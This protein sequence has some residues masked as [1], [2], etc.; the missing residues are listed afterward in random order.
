MLERA[1]VAAWPVGRPCL[2]TWSRVSIL[3]P[4]LRNAGGKAS[5]ASSRTLQC[6]RRWKAASRGGARFPSA[7]RSAPVQVVTDATRSATRVPV[8]GEILQNDRRISGG[9]LGEQIGQL[10]LNSPRRSRCDAP[11]RASPPGD[12]LAGP[13]D[14]LGPQASGW[15]AFLPAPAPWRE[16][17]DRTDTRPAR[18]T[19]RSSSTLGGRAA[20]SALKR[21]AAAGWRSLQAP[22]VRC[23][24]PLGGGRHAG[25]VERGGSLAGRV[26]GKTL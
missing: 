15:I 7:G 11:Q 18:R 10:G 23:P 9:N 4:R 19:E 5:I 14:R 3:Q 2:S 22:E 26:N 25:A 8:Q 21:A 13:G 1:L 20:E 12:C 16:R 6:A 17:Q 24:P